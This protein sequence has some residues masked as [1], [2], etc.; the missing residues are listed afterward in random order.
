MRFTYVGEEWRLRAG[1]KNVLKVSLELLCSDPGCMSGTTQGWASVHLCH[2][3]SGP[4]HF[5]CSKH[6]VSNSKNTVAGKTESQPS[7]KT[8]YTGWSTTEILHPS[9][10]SGSRE[11][12][13]FPAFSW[14]HKPRW[15]H[16]CSE[17][18]SLVTE[19]PWEPKSL[20]LFS[21]DLYD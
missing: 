21:Q 19:L 12:A 10:L 8:G 5:I 20:S 4:G 13:I 16:H 9:V 2:L 14:R 6:S 15:T 17:P 3:A 7:E 1:V 18:I 11:R